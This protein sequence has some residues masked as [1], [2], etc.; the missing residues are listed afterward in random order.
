MN[1]IHRFMAFV[2]DLCCD[3]TDDSKEAI[4][5]IKEKVNIYL[6]NLI[7]NDNTMDS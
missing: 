3:V 4:L 5:A 7:N 6:D 1:K 2:M